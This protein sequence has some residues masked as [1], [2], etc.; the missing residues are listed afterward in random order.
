MVAYS[1]GNNVEQNNEEVLVLGENNPDIITYSRSRTISLY[2]Y[3]DKKYS[4]LRIPYST[5]KFCKNARAMGVREVIYEVFHRPDKSPL[6]RSRLDVWGFDSYDHYLYTICELGFLEGLIPVIDL[7]FLTPDELERLSEVV[8]I[9]KIPVF[10][11]YDLLMDTDSIRSLDRSLEIK[12]KLLNWSSKLG[13]PISTGLFLT[14]DL[15]DEKINEFINLIVA[16][17]NEFG[18]VHEIV[19]QKQS[20]SKDIS[21]NPATFKKVKECYLKL[22]E[23][24]SE[25]VSV[26][27]QDPSTDEIEL[28]LDNNEKDLGSFDERYFSTEDGI[29]RW[30]EIKNLIE[31]KNKKLQQRFPLRRAFIENQQYSK[32]LGQVFD[33]FRYKLK[34]EKLE[35]QKDNK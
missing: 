17:S 31:K 32:K 18:C 10:S 8:A 23:K 21:Y 16:I 4:S 6:L 29:S 1:L 3:S 9:V 2:T 28:L 7:G 13:L 27:I 11:D 15:D 19:I 20:R 25:D 30:S 14:Q 33:P 24:I 5:I 12:T 35:K 22:K 26:L 34:K